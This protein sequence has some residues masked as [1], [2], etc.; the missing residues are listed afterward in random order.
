MSPVCGP[1]NMAG[2][3]STITQHRTRVC[4]PQ[5]L[6]WAAVHRAEVL[7]A[8]CRYV[9]VRPMHGAPSL[10]SG[11]LLSISLKL[12]TCSSLSAIAAQSNKTSSFWNIMSFHVVAYINAS[13]IS[14]SEPAVS[15]LAACRR[16]FAS[17]QEPDVCPCISSGS[18]RCSVGLTGKPVYHGRIKPRSRCL[19]S[20]TAIPASI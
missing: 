8:L 17:V 10:E 3:T 9:L 14:P 5:T 19:T 11:D 2:T 15:R 20:S 7:E 12:Q 13:R 4:I 18:P 1:T 6:D 16:P